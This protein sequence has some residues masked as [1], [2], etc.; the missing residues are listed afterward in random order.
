[1][2]ALNFYCFISYIATSNKSGADKRGIYSPLGS[3]SKK[4]YYNNQE[5]K[6]RCKL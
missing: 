1:M 2:K 5:L 3:K 4:K 6:S